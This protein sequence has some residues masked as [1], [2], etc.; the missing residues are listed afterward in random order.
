VTAARYTVH[1][2]GAAQSSGI[3]MGAP[4]GAT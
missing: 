1:G 4:D 2:L 3:G